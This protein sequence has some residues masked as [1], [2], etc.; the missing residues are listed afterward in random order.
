[1]NF[2]KLLLISASLGIGS[3]GIGYLIS[4]VFMY[5]FYDI[6]ILSTNEFNMVRGAYGGLFLSF[7]V[8]FF[9]GAFNEKISTLSLVS[10]FVFMSG[11]ALGRITSIVIDG[12][13][14]IFITGLL[15]CEIFYSIAS[16]YFIFL[17]KNT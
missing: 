10:L 11:F 7:S 5:G 9:I 17:H 2:K 1:M 12:A 15:L 8:L 4:P 14:G 16:A 13:P 6:E 3:I